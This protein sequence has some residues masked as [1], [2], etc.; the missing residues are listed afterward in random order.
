[1]FRRLKALESEVEQQK[2]VEMR[3]MLDERKEMLE[4]RRVRVRRIRGDRLRSKF[5]VELKS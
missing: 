3:R 2:M 1:M 5:V 4:E